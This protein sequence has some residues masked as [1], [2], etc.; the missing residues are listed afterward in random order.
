M[1]SMPAALFAILVLG[2][3][4]SR[5]QAPKTDRGVSTTI[6]LSKGAGALACPFCSTEG[7]GGIAGVA[8]IDA[9]VRRGVRAGL[10]MQWWLSGGG[11]TSRSVMFAAP[12]AHLYPRPDGPLFLTVGVGYGQYAISSD[13]EEL[14]S[15]TLAG[16]MGVSYAFKLS[17]RSAL[18][19]YLSHV[20]GAAGSLRLNGARVPTIGGLTLLQYGIAWSRR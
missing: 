7:R 14:R 2:P 13:E 1:R 8:G 15:T 19:P 3:A 17:P 12:V 4:S 20:S 9:G 16:I 18:V 6:G 11:G 10:V 5:G